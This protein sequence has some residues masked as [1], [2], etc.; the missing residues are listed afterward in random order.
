M[1][2]FNKKRILFILVSILIPITLFS[3]KS[4]L[5]TSSIP[6]NYHTIIIDAGHG[7]PDGG[8]TA[9]DGTNE[10]SINLAISL[11]LQKLLEASG[12][13]VILTRSDE[14]GIYDAN[15]KNKKQSDLKNRVI[16][17]NNSNSDIFVSI[18][19]NKID[20][21]SCSGWQTFYQKNNDNSKLLAQNIQK[22]LNESI[23]KNNKREI[24]SLSGKYIMDNVKVPTVIVECGFLS[25]DQELQNLKNDNYQENLAWGIY[26]GIIDYFSNSML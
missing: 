16:L 26:T 6:V 4:T 7:F 23:Q 13:N 24:L 22:N 25:N 19:L 20:I 11:K 12:S 21:T 10:E 9:N 17:A 2:L 15:S 5:E 14:N 3:S 18:H 1:Y 8:A